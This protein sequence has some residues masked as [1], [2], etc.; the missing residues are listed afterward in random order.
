[1]GNCN[2]LERARA[3]V[4]AWGAEEGDGGEDEFWGATAAEFSGGGGGGARGGV[5][6]TRKKEIIKD[7]GGGGEGSSSP[8]RRVKIRMTKGQLRRLLA[9]AGRGA[10]VE[11][12]V[13]E[14]MSMGDVHVEPV[15]AEEG[16]GGRRPPPSPSKL[17]PIQEDMDE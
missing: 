10:A 15:K 6:S 11:D 16:G 4:T 14:I 17:E 2:C 3:K 8:T 9:G 5:P 1:M 7:G 13:A 12:V